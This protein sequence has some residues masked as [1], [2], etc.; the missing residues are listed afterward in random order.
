MPLLLQLP[1]LYEGGYALYG[2]VL[3]VFVGAVF[4]VDV[5]AEQFA[6]AV[7][8][9]GAGGAEKGF[10]YVVAALVGLA[11]DEFDEY[12]GLSFGEAFQRRFIL[13]EDLTLHLLEV[14]FAFFF[15]FESL[16][17]F[18]GLGECLGN[19]FGVRESLAY[20]AD[21]AP[22][23]LFLLF[24]LE[25]ERRVDVDFVEHEH[26]H[27][28]A[29]D[30]GMVLAAEHLLTHAFKLR[31]AAVVGLLRGAVSRYGRDEGGNKGN[32]YFDMTFHDA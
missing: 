25:P 17:I 29:V 3:L 28:V 11:A 21:G 19:E 2:G 8:E 5:D 31:A 4:A 32:R 22:V 18:V 10:E 9:Y 7:V 23:E 27:R 14:G 26:H 13:V 1:L 30:Y 15:R 12:L 6:E 24:V 16:E 20:V